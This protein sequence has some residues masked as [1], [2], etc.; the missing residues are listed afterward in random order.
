MPKFRSSTT[1]ETG[2]ID[3][4]KELEI[5]DTILR[6]KIRSWSGREEEYGPFQLACRKTGT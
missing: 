1:K 6:K 3:T 2:V 4:G 5:F